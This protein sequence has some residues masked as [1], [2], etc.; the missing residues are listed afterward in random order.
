MDFEKF[1]IPKIETF[2]GTEKGSTFITIAKNKGLRMGIRVFAAPFPTKEDA[3]VA[4]AFRLRV[5][6]EGYNVTADMA[7]E[8]FGNFPFYESHSHASVVGV[9]PLVALPCSPTEVHNH[10][11]SF[12]GQVEVNLL[13]QIKETFGTKGATYCL[14]EALIIETLQE[15]IKDLLPE[16]KSTINETCKV[17]WIDPA[18][19]KI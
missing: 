17:S 10:Y 2:S 9:I 8:S 18:T 7:K 13:A 15:T 12:K 14:D 16:V 3:W 6:A 4:L 5:E 11:M 1:E 19:G